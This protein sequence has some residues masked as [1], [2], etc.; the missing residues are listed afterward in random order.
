MLA[1]VSARLL[2]TADDHEDDLRQRGDQGQDHD[3]FWTTGP[4]DSKPG[5]CCR[6]VTELLR[7]PY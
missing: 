3:R 7:D 4:R 6:P 1:E 2:V 5:A